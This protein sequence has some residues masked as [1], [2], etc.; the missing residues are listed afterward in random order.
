MDHGD[1]Q[2]VPRV[3]YSS[4]C[5]YVVYVCELRPSS[6]LK[7]TQS[8]PNLKSGHNCDSMTWTETYS[9]AK[10]QQC[11]QLSL[12]GFLRYVHVSSGQYLLRSHACLK[13]LPNHSPIENS[14]FLSR[15]S[16]GF[17]SAQRAQPVIFSAKSNSGMGNC[18][19]RGISNFSNPLLMVDNQLWVDYNNRYRTA[20]VFCLVS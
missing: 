8:Q 7:H 5:I 18:C 1:E 11:S 4:L 20:L 12:K 9:H 13:F 6:W 19:C 10:R 3:V 16:R 14:L 2:W 17:A 15:K